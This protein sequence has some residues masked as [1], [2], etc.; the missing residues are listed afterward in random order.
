[1]RAKDHQP[2]PH[3]DSVGRKLARDDAIMLL[4]EEQAL[5]RVLTAERD[6]LRAICAELR[7]HLLLVLPAIDSYAAASPVMVRRA[8][9]ARTFL[10]NLEARTALALAKGDA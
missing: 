2:L 7:D 5:R 6:A 1:M 10:R 9:D 4:R 8:F 3:P